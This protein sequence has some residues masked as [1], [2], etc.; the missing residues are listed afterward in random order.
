M[1][2]VMKS[3]SSLIYC[4]LTAARPYPFGSRK[5]LFP[6]SFSGWERWWQL[7]VLRPWHLDS[8]GCNRPIFE[9]VS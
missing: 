2:Y 1:V 6:I 4:M 7:K 3:W 9:K 8:I 5:S